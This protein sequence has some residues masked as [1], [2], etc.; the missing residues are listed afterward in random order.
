MHTCHT[1]FSHHHLL[2]APHRLQ[3][4]HAR[5]R[6]PHP[7]ERTNQPTATSTT[8]AGDREN[9]RGSNE[10]QERPAHR[11]R[12]VRKRDTPHMTHQVWR[13]P[14]CTMPLTT[15]IPFTQKMM[16]RCRG[17]TPNDSDSARVTLNP[18][19]APL[20]HHLC[21]HRTRPHLASK[22]LTN[23]LFP[24]E[25]CALSIATM[26]GCAVTYLDTSCCNTYISN[27]EN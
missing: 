4:R 22:L 14:L 26:N 6:P 2:L 21:E 7:Y 17:A 25:A 5:C 23:L 12:R 3:Q 10:E 15:P 18:A 27:I 8:P 11:G 19:P 9:G 16:V 24:F 20:S 13:Q 1:L